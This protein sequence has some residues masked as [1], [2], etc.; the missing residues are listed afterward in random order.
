[1]HVT[2]AEGGGWSWR[3]LLSAVALSGAL[4]ACDETCVLNSQCDPNESCSGGR[5][6][7][8][9]EGWIDCPKDEA[10]IDNVC[11][12][13]P[14]GYCERQPLVY[15]GDTGVVDELALSC[16][17][18]DGGYPPLLPPD[19]RPRRDMLP[20]RDRRPIDLDRGPLDQGAVDQGADQGVLE[21]GLDRGQDQGGDAELGVLD[22]APPDQEID[23]GRPVSLTSWL[24][25]EDNQILL[26]GGIR[27]RGRGQISTTRAPAA[28]VPG[29]QRT[30]ER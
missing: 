12:T 11:E 25:T 4:F 30:W 29:R 13:P 23:R 14:A 24:T 5:C 27:F 20:R 21:R 18:P 19:M 26:P 22:Q 6:K 17:P 9:C 28:H 7:T 2:A 8:R 3:A 1:M 10:C 16:A 15:R